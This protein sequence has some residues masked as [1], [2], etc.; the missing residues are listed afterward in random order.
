ME[1]ARLDPDS[2]FL[3]VFS[4]LTVIAW[5]TTLVWVGER[6][7]A[8]NA[9]GWGPI[10]LLWLSVAVSWVQFHTGTGWWR[11]V[12]AGFSLSAVVLSSCVG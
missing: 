2:D 10:V 4:A 3:V 1:R 5:L 11:G 8:D 9:R 12:A 6:A 7:E